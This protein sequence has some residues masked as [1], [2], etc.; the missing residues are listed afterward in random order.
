MSN[1]EKLCSFKKHSFNVHIP[2]NL[3]SLCKI[4]S[5]SL[6]VKKFSAI[7]IVFTRDFTNW[8]SQAVCTPLPET[9]ETATMFCEWDM[10]K[11]TLPQGKYGLPFSFLRIIC[12]DTVI[13]LKGILV[14]KDLSFRTG[15]YLLRRAKQR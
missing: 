4:Y 6:P 5:L 10:L 3:F 11:S 13:R 14:E 2:K 15:A 12:G 1:I 9:W 8:M 7:C